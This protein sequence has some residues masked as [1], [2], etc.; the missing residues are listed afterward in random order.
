M[1]DLLIFAMPDDIS[2]NLESV[3]V[4]NA[5]TGEFTSIN[6]TFQKTGVATSGLVHVRKADIPKAEELSLTRSFEIRAEAVD[7]ESRTVEL[8]FSSDLPYKRW[9]GTEVLD[10][11]DG[12]DFS[13]LNNAAALLWNHDWD[14]QIGVVES[15]Q[16]DG[17]KG[18]AKVRFSKSAE[19]EEAWQDVQDGIKR[20]VS[21]GYRVL[22]M[23]LEKESEED[24]E[25]YRV[26]KWAPYEISLV[27]VPA[28]ATVG[29]GREAEKDLVR[30][31]VKEK[32]EDKN[33]TDKNIT[34]KKEEKKTSRP[35]ESGQAGDT[36]DHGGGEKTDLGDGDL[37]NKDITTGFERIEM[38][39]KIELTAEQER[40]RVSGINK[41]SREEAYRMHCPA[42]RVEKWIDEGTSLDEVRADLLESFGAVKA[43][44]SPME[45]PNK[46]AQEFSIVRAIRQVANGG[47]LEGL[48]KEVSDAT[49]KHVKREAQGFFV[50]HAVA[51]RALTANTGSA[52]G[53]TVGTELQTGSMVQLLR[54]KTKV[55]GLGARTLTGL[56]GDVAIPK[57]T[58]GATS[59]WLG[60]TESAP[61]SQQ[62]FGQLGMTPHRLVGVTPFSKQL[63]NQS[64][65]DIESFVR[66]DIASVLAIAKDLACINGS[67]ADG[68]PRGIMN[69]TGINAGVTFGGAPTWA[70]VV[71]FETD[72]FTDNAESENMAFL[73]TPGVQ[74]KWKTVERA[75]GTAKFLL[76]DERRANGY[77]F[78]VTNQVPDNKVIFGNW[79][80]LIMAEWDGYDI[81]VDPYTLAGSGQ[82]KIT[83]TL[84]CDMAVRHPVSFSVS[85]DAGNQ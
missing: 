71:Q 50:P 6:P 73:S 74:G 5:G 42:D 69:T 47:K 43:P 13:R 39:D 28:D 81:V 52:G 83:I 75:S 22:E 65:L 12:A 57:Q 18:I 62:T 2:S 20:N 56:V 45:L 30:S 33:I 78:E 84:L 35:A 27:S 40:A 23:V 80:D 38:A 29:V 26:T 70:D 63:L 54:N 49:A 48:E 58:G 68:E 79:A 76:D 61:E 17:S 32:K 66:M 55:S 24:G 9:W 67:G 15:A 36:E 31:M 82:V 4:S 3:T 51:S 16:V 11:G 19:G 77:N 34:E 10:H 8:S 21:V 7:A 60:E 14:K 25:E 53:Y 46:E 72:I 59:Y 44:S 85:T 37:K 64:S 1:R 41:L